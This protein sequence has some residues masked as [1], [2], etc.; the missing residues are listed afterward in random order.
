MKASKRKKLE[1]K[2]WRV[3]DAKDFLGLSDSEAE[4]IELKL[5]LAQNLRSLRT[6]RRIGQEKVAEIIKSSQSR[7]AK[8]EAADESVTIDLIVRASLALGASRSNLGRI[9]S[10]SGSQTVSS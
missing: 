8:M 3:G 9:I 10:K 7:V 5:A 6:K 1:Q 2:G 4:Y